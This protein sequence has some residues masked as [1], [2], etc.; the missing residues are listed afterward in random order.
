MNE[1]Q[2]IWNAHQ[3]KIQSYLARM[4]GKHEAEDLMQE[5]FLK[6]YQDFGKFR[7]DSQISTW[8]YKI[9]TNTALDKLRSSS[10]KKDKRNVSIS[11]LVKEITDKEMASGEKQCIRKEMNHC[12]RTFVENLPEKYRTVMVL[13]ELEELQNSEIADILGI[14]I[15]NVK[16]QLHRAR[17]K[18]REELQTHCNFYRGENNELACDLKNQQPPKNSHE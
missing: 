7:G 8:L 3:P 18:L 15:D 13:S 5:V 17:A 9:A 2:E 6:A 11:E 14:S 4:V 16:I 1:F 12:I 10:Y